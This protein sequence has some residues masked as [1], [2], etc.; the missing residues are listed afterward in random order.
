VCDGSYI[1]PESLMRTPSEMLTHQYFDSLRHNILNYDTKVL[2]KE[3]YIYNH[4]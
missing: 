2:F 1:P 4:P 3:P